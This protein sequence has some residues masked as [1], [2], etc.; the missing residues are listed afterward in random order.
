MVCR[1]V[2]SFW[3]S[4]SLACF[5]PICLAE[6]PKPPR[7]QCGNL[8]GCVSEPIGQGTWN[9]GHYLKAGNYDSTERILAMFD[10]I[11]DE[12]HIKGIMW[13]RTWGD[14]E[15]GFGSY[16]FSEMDAILA[17]AQEVNKQAALMVLTRW[18]GGTKNVSPNYINDSANPYYKSEYGEGDWGY[19]P[20]ENGDY[21][22]SKILR[23]WNDATVARLIAYYQELG[24]RFDGHP[25][26]E[27][28]STTET[29]YKQSV[30]KNT[31][32][33][34]NRSRAEQNWFSFVSEIQSAWPRT[35]LR[36]TANYHSSHDNLNEMVKVTSQYGGAIGG[37]DVM[38]TEPVESS[39]IGQQIYVGNIGDIDYRGQMAFISQVERLDLNKHLYI[40]IWRKLR[41]DLQATH[42]FWTQMPAGHMNSWH[43]FVL[44]FI[45]ETASLEVNKT[46]PSNRLE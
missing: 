32:T 46:L 29:A 21:E 28:V 30:A 25:N 6:A 12:P 45:R 36:L 38:P 1:L 3:F 20:D 33:D 42:I 31:E 16:D 2:A 11:A 35:M 24:R 8:E 4:L 18:F 7:I 40:D 22:V 34:F 43:E 39:T 23:W 37:P 44:P 9:P 14:Y 13:R 5:V 27:F 19:L 10:A 15:T 17:K 41:D 26:L